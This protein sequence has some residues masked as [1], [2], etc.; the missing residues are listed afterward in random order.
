M[1]QTMT[2]TIDS[3]TPVNGAVLDALGLR[4]PA[5][6]IERLTQI[7]GLERTIAALRAENLALRI[8]VQELER[9]LLDT[10]EDG[11]TPAGSADNG[12]PA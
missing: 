3:V 6:G 8:H 1:D 4:W 11:P 5:K 7:Q 10:R 9:L 12:H 2:T